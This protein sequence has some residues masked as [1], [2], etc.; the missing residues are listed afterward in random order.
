MLC[1]FKQASKNLWI[2]T[3]GILISRTDF[4]T[5]LQDHRQWFG[6]PNAKACDAACSSQALPRRPH[7]EFLHVA[8]TISWLV[9]L[10]KRKWWPSTSSICTAINAEKGKKHEKEYYRKWS[11]STLRIWGDVPWVAWQWMLS[12]KGMKQDR[13]TLKGA[14]TVPQCRQAAVWGGARWEKTKGGVP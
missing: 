9:L 14:I 6:E 4:M 13:L 1:I 3:L 7:C 11:H 2:W 8:M 12:L 5:E 10:T